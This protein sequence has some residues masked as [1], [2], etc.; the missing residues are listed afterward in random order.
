MKKKYFTPELKVVEL[1]ERLMDFASG[2]P[3]GEL[4]EPTDTME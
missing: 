3:G 2:E 1:K 4:G